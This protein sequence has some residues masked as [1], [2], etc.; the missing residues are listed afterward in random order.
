MYISI[1][2]LWWEVT[3][4]F[5]SPPQGCLICPV[6]ST[7]LGRQNKIHFD[8]NILYF[9]SDSTEVNKF[10]CSQLTGETK[11]MRR[12]YF[13]I[14]FVLVARWVLEVVLRAAAGFYAYQVRINRYHRCHSFWYLKPR[15]FIGDTLS[16]KR[17]S[18][19]VLSR[20]IHIIEICVWYIL[21]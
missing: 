9:H 19:S 7:D 20:I 13:S 6:G 16:G 15:L 10:K 4:R 18:I 12:L 8:C 3:T 2:C 1:W 5:H 21:C 14:P 11:N 17:H